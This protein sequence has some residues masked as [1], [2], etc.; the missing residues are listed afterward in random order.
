M[1]FQ[2]ITLK[3]A[4]M[5]SMAAGLGLAIGL[6]TA[7]WQNKKLQDDYTPLPE[8]A[9][10]S[11][12][13]KGS[14]VHAIMLDLDKYGA[15]QGTAIAELD[16]FRTELHE[17][18]LGKVSA[19]FVAGGEEELARLAN[20]FATSFESRV[21]GREAVAISY[22]Y[23]NAAGYKNVVCAMSGFLKNYPRTEMFNKLMHMRMDV[24][25]IDINMDQFREMVVNH[26]LA[27][28]YNAPHQYSR[29]L[30][31][32]L[33]DGYAALTH[34][35]QYG[36]TKLPEQ[37][38]H[39][40]TLGLV[41]DG[42]GQ[43]VTSPALAAVIE[44]GKAAY[45][46]GELEGLAPEQIFARSTEMVLGPEANREQAVVEYTQVAATLTAARQE[47]VQN[48][49]LNYRTGVLMPKNGRHLLEYNSPALH[50]YQMHQ[51]AAQSLRG[52]APVLAPEQQFEND[53]NELLASQTPEEQVSA[54]QFQRFNISKIAR[55]RE[56]AGRSPESYQ[57]VYGFTTEQRL[58]RI[59]QRLE[60]VREQAA[61]QRVAAREVGSKTL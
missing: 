20:E 57:D 48:Y 53:M 54:L 29:L 17:R 25:G 55:E 18:I 35:Q 26:E 58:E 10:F 39:M 47:I 2:Q 28:C 43:Y 27:H 56:A 49:N 19:R 7:S 6:G 1:K 24:S 16:R 21:G 59:E 30:N 52:N 40:R 37:F 38:M 22:T 32:S 33:A 15:G 41:N 46:R 9:T 51:Q 42:S 11:D 13:Q 60:Q 36:S 3:Q 5:G 45:E 44:K 12:I 14:N 23:D 8:N 31:E 34:I 61:P 50:L 4:M